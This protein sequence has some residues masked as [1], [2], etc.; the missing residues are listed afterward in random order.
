MS[1]PRFLIVLFDGL[2][3]D[4]IRP[5]LMPNLHQ[6]RHGWCDYPNSSSAFPSETRVQASSIVTGAFPGGPAL[7]PGQESGQGHG[8]MANAFYD[9]V[10]RFDRPLDTSDDT[11][12]AQARS[13]YG[14][15]Q[16]AVS[17]GELLAQAGKSYA[18]VTTGTIGNAR[19]LNCFAAELGQPVFSTKGAAISVPDTIYAESVRRFGPVPDSAI[20]DTAIADYATRVL[21]EY[22]IPVHDVDVQVLWYNE[23]DISYHYRGIGSPESETA[24]RTVDNG[25]GRIL[26]WWHAE[27]RREGWHIVAASD[28]AQITVTRQVGLRDS[29]DAAGFRIGRALAA[30]CDVAVKPGYSGHILV[31]DRDPALIGKVRAFLQEQDWCGLVFTRQGGDG[32]LPLGTINLAS[33]RAPDISYTMRTGNGVNA[34]G[35]P[36]TCFA[37]NPDI[38]IGGGLHGGLHRIE[39]NNLLVLGGNEIRAESV[40]NVP[41][42]VIDIV[43]TILHRLGVDRPRTMVGRP[44]IEAFTGAGSE[45]A[46]REHVVHA[47]CGRYAQAMTI[48][49]VE[50]GRASYLRG[51]QRTG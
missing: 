34:F 8:I 49:D 17:L 35:Y 18:V 45:P 10:L 29:L 14:R 23:P 31:R 43:P 38:P 39:I 12:M 44:M 51:G 19:L 21:L 9:P 2:R 48:A 36:G 47:R 13:M 33:E 30:D 11:R 27:G 25:F 4:M 6:F 28:H 42:G 50:G 41:T 26:D 37:D 5:D 3:R 20:P 46:W 24:A 40:Q 7:L 1:R 32:A 15:M 22:F 16:K